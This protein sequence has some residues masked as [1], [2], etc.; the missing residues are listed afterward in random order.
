MTHEEFV[1]LRKLYRAFNT[2]W[3]LSPRMAAA[4]AVMRKRAQ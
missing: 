3:P 4:L 2:K 1:A